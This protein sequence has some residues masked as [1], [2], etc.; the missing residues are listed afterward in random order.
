MFSGDI[1]TSTFTR[2][3]MQRFDRNNNGLTNYREWCS[4]K[5]D[6][7]NWM[8][9]PERGTDNQVPDWDPKTGWTHVESSM[10][11]PEDGSTTSTGSATLKLKRPVTIAKEVWNKDYKGEMSW[12]LNASQWLSVSWGKFAN[13]GDQD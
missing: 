2:H 1:S 6:E 13:K 11:K 5:F 10:T 4:K 12:E 8:R 7:Y 9:Q 3:R